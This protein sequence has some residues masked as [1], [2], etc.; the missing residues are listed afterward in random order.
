ML[1]TDE[2]QAEY[3]VQC[4]AFDQATVVWAA[5]VTIRWDLPTHDGDLQDSNAAYTPA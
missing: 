3:L 1:T 4:A 2:T 5:P